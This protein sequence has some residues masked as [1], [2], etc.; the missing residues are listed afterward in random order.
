MH[1]IGYP[2]WKWPIQ[3]WLHPMQARISSVRSSA[4]LTGSSGSQIRA[5]VIAQAPACPPAMICSASWGWLI[6]P[7]TMTGT[8]T[9]ARTLVASGAV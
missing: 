2:S 9:T 7:A 8:P 4:A 3:A 6:R 5:L 1:E